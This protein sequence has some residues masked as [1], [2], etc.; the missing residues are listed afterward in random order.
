MSAAPLLRLAHS[1]FT[2]IH[3]GAFFNFF[4][5]ASR[6]IPSRR[7]LLA[8]AG[9]P[10]KASSGKGQGKRCSPLAGSIFLLTDYCYVFS[11][12]SIHFASW[13]FPDSYL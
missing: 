3:S 4:V 11:E 9:S 7:D 5:S 10:A 13:I 2:L 6:G 1:F 12:Q 8:G